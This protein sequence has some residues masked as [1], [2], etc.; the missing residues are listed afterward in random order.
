MST[1]IPRDVDAFGRP[2]V[3]DYQT[4]GFAA[5]ISG[6]AVAPGLN[7]L[8]VPQAPVLLTATGT[9]ATST[10]LV[11]QPIYPQFGGLA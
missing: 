3:R 5:F 6:P 4:S 7:N 8:A 2:S 1:A 9:P 10:T 11:T